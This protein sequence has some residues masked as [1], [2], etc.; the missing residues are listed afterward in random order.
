M[1]ELI[2]TNV[3]EKIVLMTNC[4]QRRFLPDAWI[5]AIDENYAPAG[6]IS[7]YCVFEPR[8]VSR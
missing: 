5:S 1:E 8:S 4:K 6:V 3:F 7:G 2:K